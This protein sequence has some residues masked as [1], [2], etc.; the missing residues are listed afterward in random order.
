[1]TERRLQMRLQPLSPLAR[2]PGQ[3]QAQEPQWTAAVIE[4][5]RLD[6]LTAFLRGWLD[7]QHRQASLTREQQDYL[8]AWRDRGMP[9]SAILSVYRFLHDVELH[10]DSLTFIN[11]CLEF[12]P[13]YLDASHDH[14]PQQ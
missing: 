9:T 3:G 7:L 14:L 2:G 1:M 8:K 6:D 12:I 11:F 4:N 13:S 10:H 5:V